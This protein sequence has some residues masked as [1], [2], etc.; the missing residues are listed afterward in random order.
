MK[1]LKK[2]L[3]V[4]VGFCGLSGVYANE[5]TLVSNEENTRF[6]LRSHGE[7][8]WR[9]AGTGKII[10]V[11]L[12]PKGAYEFKAQAPGY[13][14][15][16]LTLPELV[17][18]IQFTFMI[19]DKAPVKSASSAS[20]PKKTVKSTTSNSDKKSGEGADSKQTSAEQT[21]KVSKKS[22]GVVD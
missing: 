17:S 20:K 14:E 8:A 1:I 18:E 3:F 15:K 12:A 11:E 7:E 6:L 16:S 9:D 10:R 2:I 5:V 21:E 19:G 13:I 4:F 22:A